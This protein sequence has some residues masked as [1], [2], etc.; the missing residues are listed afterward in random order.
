MVKSKMSVLDGYLILL[1]TTQFGFLN[2]SERRELVPLMVRSYLTHSLSNVKRDI[3][4]TSYL[5]RD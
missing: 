3:L 1:I 2:I 4:L 5:K